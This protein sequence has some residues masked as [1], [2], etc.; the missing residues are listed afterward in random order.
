MGWQCCCIISLQNERFCHPAK[1]IG[2]QTD[3]LE[4]SMNETQENKIGYARLVMLVIVTHT[5]WPSY[6]FHL[7]SKWVMQNFTAQT[8]D[9]N[10][11]G[12]PW[13]NVNWS[14]IPRGWTLAF[15]EPFGGPQPGVNINWP[16]VVRGLC[17][18]GFDI[19]ISFYP[20]L[21]DKGP[22]WV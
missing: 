7:V 17:M 4:E 12:R 18:V 20:S 5:L 1:E 6:Q 15:K 13:G 9:C 19:S 2:K 22:G 11:S 16:F 21:M 10:G 8:E 14:G 3:L